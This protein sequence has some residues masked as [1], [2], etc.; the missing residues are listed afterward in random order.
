M[1][2]GLAS[3][4]AVGM[5]VG[6]ALIVLFTM[7]TRPAFTMSDDEIL[8]KVRSLPEVQA[9]YERYTPLEQIRR[10][11]TATYVTYELTRQVYSADNIDSDQAGVFVIYDGYASLILTV[12]VDSFGKMSMVVDCGGPVSIQVSENVLNFIKTTDCIQPQGFEYASES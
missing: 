9:Y 3:S 11:G 12:K 2:A 8:E 4:V 5:A 7:N 1:S 10:E 6:I